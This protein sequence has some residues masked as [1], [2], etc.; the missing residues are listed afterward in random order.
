MKGFNVFPREV[1]EA[2]YAHPEVA[3]VGVVGVPD[4]RTG[5]E[6]L[7]AYRGAARGRGAV[8]GRRSRRTSRSGSSATSARTTSGSSRRC[9]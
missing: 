8:G 4:A 6:R 3:A 7:V 1:E 2:L 9:R 5:G